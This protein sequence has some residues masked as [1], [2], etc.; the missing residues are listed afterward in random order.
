LGPRLNGKKHYVFS[1][2][3][4]LKRIY[5]SEGKG[6]FFKDSPPPE[7]LGVYESNNGT[8]METNLP[9]E[10]QRD[11]E[12]NVPKS[13]E[14]LFPGGKIL[15]YHLPPYLSDCIRVSRVGNIYSDVVDL[16]IDVEKLCKILLKQALEN[17][18]DKKYD[19]ALILLETLV[20]L[21]SNNPITLYNLA[22]TQS[23]R[24]EY[25]KAI[26]Y[27]RR[28]IEKG[29]SNVDHMK[30]DQ[31]LDNIRD[32]PEYIALVKSLESQAEE[33]ITPALLLRP[34]EIKNNNPQSEEL[35]AVET[36]DQKPKEKQPYEEELK[37]LRELG[38]MDD[39]KNRRL[40]ISHQGDVAAVVPVLLDNDTD[41]FFFM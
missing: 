4:N 33:E 12:I 16:D 25:G 35:T 29:F 26:E 38:F 6:V 21:N 31:D 19:D 23:L 32:H 39:E 10:I 2:K 17:L 1:G 13:L 27:L 3:S 11:L 34:V 24:K 28:A 20:D 30:D 9:S 15:P 7:V 41:S 5:I 18:D 37:V 36:Q 14:R 8:A 40:L 22:C